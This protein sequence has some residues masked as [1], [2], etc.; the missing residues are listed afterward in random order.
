MLTQV[1]PHVQIVL[2]KLSSTTQVCFLF[3]KNL[4]FNVSFRQL[5]LTQSRASSEVPILFST[6]RSVYGFLLEDSLAINDMMR[7]T[8][9]RIAYVTRDCA[10]FMI[11]RK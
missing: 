10:H 4:P 1:H 7:D 11:I 5:I 6:I 9:A 3:S 2:G 8:L